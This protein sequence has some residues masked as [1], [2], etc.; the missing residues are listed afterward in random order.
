MSIKDITITTVAIILAIAFSACGNSKKETEEQNTQHHSDD[1]THN[2]SEEA[3]VNK[4]NTIV[5]EETTTTITKKQAEKIL[6]GYLEIK[7]A[8]VQA[9]GTAASEAATKLVN[10]KDDITNDKLAKKIH[11]DAEHIA[12]THDV[13]HQRDHLNSLS[14][15]VFSLIKQT[16]A[17]NTTLYLQS[18]PMEK[19]NNEALWLSLD[20]EIINPYFGAQMLNC[21]NMEDTL[22]K[23]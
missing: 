12:S 3:H 15:N 2:H 21:G 10:E 20:T 13:S 8:L 6:S 18:C 17:N 5:A 22:T 14:K 7:D 23:N 11:S 4:E 1:S 9:N 19:N 16:K